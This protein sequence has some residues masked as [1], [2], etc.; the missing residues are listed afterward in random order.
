MSRRT[1]LVGNAP[2]R[3]RV[4]DLVDGAD[5]VVRFNRARGVG[6]SSG[7][8]TDELWLVNHGGQMAEWLADGA[9]GDVAAV[10]A[11]ATVVLPI[12]MLPGH[13]AACAA[14]VAATDAGASPDADRINHVDEAHRVLADGGHVV[15]R[16]GIDDYR[17]AQRAL[18]APDP[19]V[20]EHYPSTGFIAIVRT[21]ARATTGDR[22]E[23]V[24]FTFEG[25]RGHSW[26]AERRWVEARAR[27]GRLS[28]RPVR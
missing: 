28:V 26:N 15:E 11:G 14:R 5:R 8:R 22:V 4:A 18:G 10:A 19:G 27:E 13:V 2:M 25:W 21:L 17:G 9:L 20:G 16:L 24:G 12:P 6:T 1:V 23:L 7:S 3:E